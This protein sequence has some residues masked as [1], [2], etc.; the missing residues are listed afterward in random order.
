M[1][2]VSFVKN[3]IGTDQQRANF[4]EVLRGVAQANGVNPDQ[5]V[6]GA[7]KLMQT[8]EATGR[9]PGAGSPTAGRADL[10]GQLGK[11]GIANAVNVFSSAPLKSLADKINA[12]M[13]AGR[14]NKLA[15][16][17]TAPDSVQQIMKM[18]KLDPRGITAQYYVAALLGLDRAVSDRND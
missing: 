3:V 9:I 6:A 10:A 18:A 17:F 11:S 16:A 7:N 4:E 1:M 15:E 12:A 2:G 5:Y 14:Y 13:M 8:L